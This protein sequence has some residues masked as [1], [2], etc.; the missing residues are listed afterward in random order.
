M[1]GFPS[2]LFESSSLPLQPNK[3][4]L[5]NALW[6]SSNESQQ[7]PSED[8]QYV[9]DGGA[10][11]H[12]LPWPLDPYMMMCVKCML[13]MWNKDMALLFLFLMDTPMNLQQKDVIHLIR[14]RTCL[15]VTVHFTGD[16][17]IQSKK[18]EFVA[19]KENKTCIGQCQAGCWCANNCCICTNQTY[20]LNGWWHRF[21]CLLH[22]D[23][24]ANNIFVS[25]ENTQTSKTDK[26]W[27]I[28]QCK[29]WW[30]SVV[31]ACNLWLWNCKFSLWIGQRNCSLKAVW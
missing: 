26:V 13:I 15:E 14:T 22:P 17:L 16:M 9:L 11:L 21:A 18:D 5:A 19:N 4:V 28:Q 23:I 27:C 20:C 1:N 12:R 8:V 2:A 6:K 7:E 3:P 24:D 10:L 30:A 31:Y 25:P 29:A